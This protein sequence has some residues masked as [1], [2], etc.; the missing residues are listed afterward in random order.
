MLAWLPWK[1]HNIS[2]CLIYAWKLTLWVLSLPF[3]KMLVS[4][5]SWGLDGIM[6]WNIVIALYAP[7]CTPSGKVTWW[8]MHWLKMATGS[9]SSRPSGCL[10]LPILFTPFFLGTVLACTSLDL[11]WVDFGFFVFSFWKFLCCFFGLVF[12][13]GSGLS[14]LFNKLLALSKKK[15]WDFCF[16]IVGLHKI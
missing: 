16:Y 5:S 12:L 9:L 8:L 11:I 10:L 2:T 13:Y 14:W 1:K 7:V 4:L 3:I 6:A 15:K